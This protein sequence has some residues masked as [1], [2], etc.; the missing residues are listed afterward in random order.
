MK[1]LIVTTRMQQAESRESSLVSIKRIAMP[2]LVISFG[3][4]SGMVF[5][6]TLRVPFDFSQSEIGIEVTVNGEPLYVLLDTG[7]DL[8]RGD[9]SKAADPGSYC[10]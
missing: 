9:V 3:L 4:R 10:P 7:V 6:Q 1:K 8:R 5:G 2:V